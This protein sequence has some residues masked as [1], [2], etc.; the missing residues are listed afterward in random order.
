[1]TEPDSLRLD[2]WLWAARFFK[3]RKLAA[4]AVSGGKVHFN[5][6]R[7][8]PSKEVKAGSH[9]VISKD[10]YTWNIVVTGINKQ[11]RPASEAALLYEESEESKAKRREQIAQQKLQREYLDHSERERKPNKKQRRQIHRFKQN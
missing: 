1:M 3:T 11:R 8:K 9:I 4:D 10:R 7:C 5:G 2:K 6:Q